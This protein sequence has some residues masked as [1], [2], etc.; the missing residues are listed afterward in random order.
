MP[1]YLEKARSNPEKAFIKY[2]EE[3]VNV[4]WWWKNG[5]EHMRDNFGVQ[6]PDTTTFQPDF[7]VMHTDNS[8][9][10]YDTKDAGFQ[11]DDNK[12]KAEALQKYIKEENTKGK[13]LV[14][15]IIIV[16]TNNKLR[17]NKK[18]IY[19]SFL[20]KPDDWEYID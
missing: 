9:G 20:N 13:N 5:D 14:G 12:I 8:L 3:S 17:I 18:E 11:E 6:K 1:C 19:N 7:I 16:D 4:K 10:I 15:G 2:L